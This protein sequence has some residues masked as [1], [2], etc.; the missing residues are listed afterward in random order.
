[1]CLTLF[2]KQLAAISE[3]QLLVEW[4]VDWVNQLVQI[5]VKFRGNRPKWI[6]VGFSDHGQ[7]EGSDGC[8]YD[9]RQFV[10]VGNG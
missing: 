5:D 3:T 7:I 10:L 6:L 9:G 4:Q 2:F 8:L 1:M